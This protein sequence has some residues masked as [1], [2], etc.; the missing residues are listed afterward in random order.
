[1]EAFAL[2]KRVMFK[3]RSIQKKRPILD[4]S[5]LLIHGDDDGRVCGTVDGEG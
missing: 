5:R 1:M 4:T 2:S 3:V